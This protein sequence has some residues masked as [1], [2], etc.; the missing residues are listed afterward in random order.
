[1]QAILFRAVERETFGD[2]ARYMHLV[3]SALV[4]YIW[5][6]RRDRGGPRRQNHET[7]GDVHS[8]GCSFEAPSVAQ[9]PECAGLFDRICIVR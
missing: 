1:V 3:R 7:R 5:I 4:H 9:G 6:E 8:L 2:L